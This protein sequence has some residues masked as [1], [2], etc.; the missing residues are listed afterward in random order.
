MMT[1]H[2]KEAAIMVVA[3]FTL[4]VSSVYSMP[5]T[6]ANDFART[7]KRHAMVLP[8]PPLNLIHANHPHGYLCVR[9]RKG[10]CRYVPVVD[11][12]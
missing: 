8:R 3:L 11:Y 6:Y 1:L 5:V 12:A 9:N 2:R 10:H 7:T 4:L